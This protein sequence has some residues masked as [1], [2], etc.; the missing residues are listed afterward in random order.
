MDVNLVT[1][2]A[3]EKFSIAALVEKYKIRAPVAWHLM[4]CMAASC[5]NGVVVVKK[6]RPHPIIRILMESNTFHDLSRQMNSTLSRLAE[7]FMAVRESRDVE[8]RKFVHLERC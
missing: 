7:R 8:F 1:W 5:K 3:L 2:E 6:Q 4:E